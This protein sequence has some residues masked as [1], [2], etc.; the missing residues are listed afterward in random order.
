MQNMF[1]PISLVDIC[2][3]PPLPLFFFSQ[4]PRFSN[5]QIAAIGK[6]KEEK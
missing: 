4:S 6:R 5:L 3:F 1:S 2:L